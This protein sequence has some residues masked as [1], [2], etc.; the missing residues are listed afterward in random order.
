[1]P[2]KK[3][4]GGAGGRMDF[5][6]VESLAQFKARTAREAQHEDSATIGQ[7]RVEKKGKET[8]GKSLY[9]NFDF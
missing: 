9:R 4:G 8:R 1:M 2:G 3:T 5:R 7:G 6:P